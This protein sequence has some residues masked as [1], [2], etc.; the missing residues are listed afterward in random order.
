MPY[1][2]LRRASAHGIEEAMVAGCRHSDQIDLL[3]FYCIQDCVD[4]IAGP[5][6]GR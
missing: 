6:G 2:A 5:R 3:L 4:H 1:H